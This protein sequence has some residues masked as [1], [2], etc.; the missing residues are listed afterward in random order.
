VKPAEM[1]LV[2]L[3]DAIASRR[4]SA[5]EAARGAID[6]AERLNPSLNAFVEL[7]RDDALRQAR[8]LDAQLKDRRRCGPFG[9]LAGVPIAL[10]DNM[11]L[12]WGK[13]TCASRMLENYRSPYTATAVQRLIDAGAVIIGK[14]NL[15]EFAM[16]S[17]TEHSMF[18]PTANPWDAS[19]VV[20]GSSGGSA[21]AV[22]AGIVPGALGSDTGGSIRQPA[23]LCGIVG[24]KPTYGLV[25]RYGL[26]AYASSLDQIGPFARSVADAALLAS[27]ICGFDPLDSTSINGPAPGL[28]SKL[29]EPVSRLVVGV[30]R[31][32]KTAANHPA[33]AAALENAVKVLRGLDAE[34]IDVEL[35]LTAHGIAAYY[36]IAPAEASSNLARFDGVRYGRRATL[37]AGEDLMDLY[38]RSRA[39]GFG[40]EVQRRIMLGTHVLSSGYY[41]A[42]YATALKVRRLIREEFD[43]AFGGEGGPSGAATG[44]CHAILMPSSPNPAW[45]IGEKAADPLSEYL[46]DVYTVGVNLA[47]LPAVTVPGGFAPGAGSGGCDLPIGVQFIGPSMEDATLLRLARMFERATRF[48]ERRP[49]IFANAGRTS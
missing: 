3:R 17:S 24:Y 44:G 40:A 15:D 37:S 11:C 30:P 36:I 19:R 45:K 7:F 34:V 46:E 9:G 6:S 48:G 33:V 41:D 49:P 20:G 21:A 13:T 27:V 47:G 10:K 14:T 31:Q 2:E 22:C 26:V 1:T 39:E 8:E 35:P 5:E 23:G 42:Y 18:G 25:S 38:C 12:A 16:G 43:S 29:D 4:L 28:V 32:A